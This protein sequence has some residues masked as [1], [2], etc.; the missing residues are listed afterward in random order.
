MAARVPPSHPSI[1]VALS[2]PVARAAMCIALHKILTLFNCP[3]NS[4]T[5]NYQQRKSSATTQ[6]PTLCPRSLLRTASIYFA[7][8]VNSIPLSVSQSNMTW[9]QKSRNQPLESTLPILI[10]NV[11]RNFS[12]PRH[13]FLSRLLS[14]LPN[15]F[16][17]P[18]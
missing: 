16:L 12:T 6:M 5:L 11:K 18:K 13:D 1:P 3:L 7:S 17:R 2:N 10:L 15:S 9:T 4:K 14:C 8:L